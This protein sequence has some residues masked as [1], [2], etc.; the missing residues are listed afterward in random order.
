MKQRVV[1]MVAW[2][3]LI[4]VTPAH[5]GYE[6]ELEQEVQQYSKIFTQPFR[7][8]QHTAAE[9]LAYAGQSDTRIFDR[10][11]KQLLDNYTQLEDSYDIDW[12]SWLVKAL[13]F[14]GNDKYLPTIRHLAAEAPDRKLRRYAGL[15]VD[16]LPQYAAWNPVILNPDHYNEDLSLSLN[17]YANMLRSDVPQ[18]HKLA[19]KRIF[20][21][22]IQQPEIVELVQYRLDQPAAT[23]DRDT[24]KWLKKSLCTSCRTYGSRP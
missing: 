21:E 14:S 2:I 4:L 19:A 23:T 17:R 8:S 11:E 13:A 24:Q 6:D 18:L 16:L 1:Q 15:S 5:A 20:F 10:V 7:M 9:A 12:A 22:G 3:C